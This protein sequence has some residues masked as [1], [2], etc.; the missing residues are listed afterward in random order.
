MGSNVGLELD[1]K[2][3]LT[4]VDLVS[5]SGQHLAVLVEGRLAESSVFGCRMLDDTLSGGQV[6]PTSREACACSH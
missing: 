5:L 3:D 6:L 2:L 1:F 4:T